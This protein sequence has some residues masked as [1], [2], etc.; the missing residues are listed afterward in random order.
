[1]PEP[2]PDESDET[3]SDG[4]EPMLVGPELSDSE[5]DVPEPEEPEP[6]ESEPDEPEPEDTDNLSLDPAGLLVGAGAITWFEFGPPT[7]HLAHRNYLAAGASF[8]LRVTLPAIG[9]ALGDRTGEYP[10]TSHGGLGLA[11]GA[12]AAT[13]LD[14][15]LLAHRK[16]DRRRFVTPQL[17]LSNQGVRVGI[18][19]AW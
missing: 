14:V 2:G 18:A 12:L 4:S 13:A 10:E 8:A 11:I 17:A 9:M 3:G 1:M 5:P 19:S 6:E 7:I 15:S 16:V